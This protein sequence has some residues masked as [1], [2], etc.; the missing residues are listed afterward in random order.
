MKAT[1][2]VAGIVVI[3]ALIGGWY[4]FMRDSNTDQSGSTPSPSTSTPSTPTAPTPTSPSP[5][6]PTPSTPS[7]SSLPAACNGVVADGTLTINYANNSFSA[8]GV[9]RNTFCVKKGTTVTFTGDN[10][11]VASDPHPVH[12][13]LPGF[14]ALGV[15]STYSF[16]FNTV[17]EHGFHN[18]MRASDT[19]TILVVE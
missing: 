15:K 14:D 9:A 11:W 12:T 5:S 3:A 2:I 8:N 1:S 13:D 17:G 19:G 4:F 18:H 7:T 16:T 6:S 10:L